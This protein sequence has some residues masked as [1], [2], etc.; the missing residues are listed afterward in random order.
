[1]TTICKSIFSLAVLLLTS[2]PLALAQGTYTQIDYPGAIY[3]AAVG[4]DTAGDVSGFYQDQSGTYH[5]F[6][7]S[8]GTYTS[9]DYPGATWTELYGLNDIGQVVGTADE[10][11][12]GFLYEIQSQTFTQLA[13]QCATKTIPYAIN[14][15]GTIVGNLI[16]LHNNEEGFELIGSTYHKIV[17]PG[18]K[19]DYLLG[20]TTS[21]GV[22]G[23]A[24]GYFTYKKGKYQPLSGPPIPHPSLTNIDPTGAILIGY[25]DPTATSMAGF[26]YQNGTVTTL[27]FPGAAFTSASG[28]NSAGQV[29]GNFF[30]I[31]GNY[32]GFLWTPP[33]DAGKK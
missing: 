17:P 24:Q 21:G 7:L 32:H 6:I 4:I 27:Q 25:Y 23:Y 3:T 8:G 13:C 9:I 20:I 14:N 5:G 28:I 19:G 11:T 26:T 1:M 18:D 16:A 2:S 22:I 15:A 29:V 31:G 30:V 12:I 10:E 33:A